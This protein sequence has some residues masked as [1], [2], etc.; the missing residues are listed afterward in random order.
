MKIDVIRVDWK[1]ASTLIV[2]I[3]TKLDNLRRANF[4]ET[5][6]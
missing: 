6:S 2:V 3:W 1:I 4:F 5:D